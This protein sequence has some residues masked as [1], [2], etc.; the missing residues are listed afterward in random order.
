MKIDRICGCHSHDGFQLSPEGLAP[1]KRQRYGL[2]TMDMFE[3]IDTV[4]SV[5]ALVE[6]ED[7]FDY[8]SDHIELNQRLIHSGS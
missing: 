6:V 3:D 8:D 5:S 1:R 2:D 7:D 4:G